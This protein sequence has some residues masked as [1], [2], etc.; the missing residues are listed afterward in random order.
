[1][2]IDITPV[3]ICVVGPCKREHRNVAIGF[4]KRPRGRDGIS[5]Y[6]SKKISPRLG[7]FQASYAPVGRLDMSHH[8]ILLFVIPIFGLQRTC[9]S[10]DLFRNIPAAFGR[11]SCRLSNGKQ[12]LHAG[13]TT[14][15]I[16]GRRVLAI[17]GAAPSQIICRR[18]GPLIIFFVI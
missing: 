11:Q 15:T 1:M 17:V 7:L 9:F 8:E 3:Q 5:E 14:I 10:M 13:I 16:H 2:A 6:I 12:F 4:A 18:Q